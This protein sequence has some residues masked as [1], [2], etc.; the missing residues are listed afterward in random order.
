M[1]SRVRRYP[2]LLFQPPRQSTTLSPLAAEPRSMCSS[3][4]KLAALIHPDNPLEGLASIKA[5]GELTKESIEEIDSQ[6]RELFASIRKLRA[7]RNA[8][9]HIAK[10]P[11]EILGNI[12]LLAPN[13]LISEDPRNREW[14]ALAQI[15]HSFRSLT[16]NMPRFWAHT[17]VV[18]H[19]KK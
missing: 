9:V 11:H 8:L 18:S 13:Q 19:R 10:L 15:C 1:K 16:L 14:R 4:A 12:L 17:D 7:R 5:H 6:I 3:S 2:A